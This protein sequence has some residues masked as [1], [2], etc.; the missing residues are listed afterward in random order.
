M[1]WESQVVL[2]REILA[3]TENPSVE[4]VEKPTVDLSMGCEV[5]AKSDRLSK[6]HD[7]E[8]RSTQQARSLKRLLEV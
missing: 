5:Q 2:L 8:I 3:Q 4:K 1:T 6:R 7:E